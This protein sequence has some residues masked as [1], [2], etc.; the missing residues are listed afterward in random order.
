MCFV[1]HGLKN[2]PFLGVDMFLFTHR[3][4]EYVTVPTQQQKIRKFGKFPQQG[5]AIRLDN[6]YKGTVTLV[7]PNFVLQ[8]RL[9]GCCARPEFEAPKIQRSK[10]RQ[11][12]VRMQVRSDHAIYSGLVLNKKKRSVWFFRN[13][14]F[15]FAYDGSEAF[16]AAFG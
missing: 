13:L 8:G 10:R 6:P 7:D 1:F 15:L 5:I 16:S 14:Y 4:L 12:A 11:S 2:L 3:S 9:H